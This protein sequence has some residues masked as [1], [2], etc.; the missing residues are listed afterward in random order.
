MILGAQSKI[1]TTLCAPHLDAIITTSSVPPTVCKSRRLRSYMIGTQSGYPR[2]VDLSDLFINPC[3]SIL[4]SVQNFRGDPSV[5]S[6]F[7]P[8]HGPMRI[9]TISSLPA[10][11]CLKGDY[12][13]E[14]IVSNLLDLF[15]LLTNICVYLFFW[16]EW[17]SSKIIFLMKEVLFCIISP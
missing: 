7:S 4:I 11:A 8:S 2:L 13:C 14:K 10:L 17:F 3:H 12:L 5:L 16:Q 6:P 15:Y 9:N 1:I